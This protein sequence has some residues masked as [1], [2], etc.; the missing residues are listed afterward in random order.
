M[1]QAELLGFLASVRGHQ[2]QKRQR[3]EV[4]LFMSHV[5]NYTT[6]LEAALVGGFLVIGQVKTI[7]VENELLQLCS[8]T[9]AP[10]DQRGRTWQATWRHDSICVEYRS[11]QAA[12]D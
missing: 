6:K 7:V 10:K 3:S 12:Q 4:D 8:A 11:V 1:T 2:L 9:E 5:R